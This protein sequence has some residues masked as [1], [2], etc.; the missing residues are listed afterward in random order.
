MNK[1]PPVSYHQLSWSFIALVVFILSL[2][3]AGYFGL[4]LR[5]S[6]PPAPAGLLAADKG[7][8]VTLDL[9]LYDEN[10]LPQ[11]LDTLHDNGLTWLRQPVAWAEIEPAPGQFNWS[12]L[13]G[14]VGQVANL[15][16]KVNLILVLQTTPAW[17]RPANTPPTTPPTEVSDFGSFAR[18]L[19]ARYGDQ[20]DY[21]QIWHEPNLAANWGNA[22]VDPAAYAG[23]LRE[24]TLNIRAADPQAVILTAALAPTLENGPLNLNELSYLDKL[25]QAKANRWF[26]VVAGQAYGFDAEPSDPARP[27]RLNFSRLE[28]LRR[29][30][31]DHGDTDTPIW[32]TAFGWNALPADWNGH[33][34][35][36]ESDT[37]EVQARRTAAAVAQARRNWP[38][39]GPM[40]AIRWDSTGLVADDPARGFALQEAAPVLAALQAASA[41]SPVATA[42]RYPAD[43]PTGHY[44]PG[45][46]FAQTQA[47]IPHHEPRTLTIPFAGTRLDLTVNRGPYRGYLWVQI[48]GQPANALPQDNQGRSYVVLYDPLRESEPV[49]LAQHLASGPHEAIIEAEGGWGQWAI[50]GWT[51]YNESDTRT[52][53][54]GFTAASIVAVLSGV[55]CLAWL[56]QNPAAPLKLVWAWAEI[57][58]ALYA[59]LGERGQVVLTFG[60]ALAFY[61]TPG[62]GALVWLSL[63]VLALLV[64]PDLGL[65]LVAFSLSFFQAYK[66]LPL[67]S[68]SPVELALA[69]SLAGFIFRGLLF[70][71]RSWYAPSSLN[72]H[73]PSSILHLLSSIFYPLSTDLAALALVALA[74]ASTLAAENFGVSMR[75]WRVVVVESVIFYFLVRLGLDFRPQL[76]ADRRPPTANQQSP[77]YAQRPSSIFYLPTWTWR[78]VDAFIAGAVLQ[79]LIALYLYFF[80]GQSITAE[81][82]RRALGLAYGSPNN[83]SLFLDR[84]WPILLAVTV[85]PGIWS[86]RRWFY[87][88]GLLVVSAALYLTFSKG[89]LL[90]GLPAGVLAMALFYVGWGQAGRR[91]W[92]PVLLAAVGGLAVLTLALI[93]LSQ[94]ERFRTVFDFNP[95]STGFFRL[96]L[97]QASLAMLRDHWPLGVGLDNFLYQYQTRYI[98]PEAWQEPNLSHPHNLIL[99]FGTRLGIGGIGLLLWLQVAFWRNAWR[100]YQKAT[101]PLIL[102]LMGSMVVFLAHGLVDNSYFLVD[103]AFAFFLT[104]G[105][106]QRLAE[107]VVQL[108]NHTN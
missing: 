61:L 65:A 62:W 38:W 100:L 54:I 70:W 95:G 67:G 9:T 84:A 52:A 43:D 56:I 34:S 16:Y 85:W 106:V 92:R 87:S 58:V 37:P 103:L 6:A 8:G 97:W 108:T 13:D 1:K 10:V 44:G 60:L 107:Q 50:G 28:L 63:L 21:Y 45:W 104:V 99:D 72:F 3:I 7:Y 22:F 80:T 17:A 74:F 14:V 94:T 69:L 2:I 86:L 98:L 42:G 32:T 83:L 5:R 35:P 59:I 57:L 18:V 20:I 68:V 46:R 75:E 101:G 19:A 31:L 29:V 105:I 24:A 77:L 66:Q 15:P 40:L 55:I 76:T 73:P 23:L 82:V 27:A 89:A 64:R 11:T 49:T 26:N 102:G 4:H 36:W 78:L 79:A 93:P 81:G 96:K 88:V 30:M 47:D 12:N 33:P 53:Q 41:N 71:G 25:Y 51:V 91:Q 39:L 48:D 90:L